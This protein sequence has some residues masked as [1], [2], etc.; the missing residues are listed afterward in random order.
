MPTE[1]LNWNT[2]FYTLISSFNKYLNK[3]WR[4]P[5]SLLC[6][7]SVPG[8]RVSVKSDFVLQYLFI[9][10]Q[11]IQKWVLCLSVQWKESKPLSLRYAEVNDRGLILVLSGSL[12]GRTK[13]NHVTNS[14]T[15]IGVWPYFEP[16]ASRT[17]CYRLSY[18][19][20]LRYTG[21]LQKM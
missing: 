9:Y 3:K 14:I 17:E 7:S 10:S 21:L 20:P 19:V 16:G 15:I 11:F 1:Y 5:W 13:E 18:H 6:Q 2:I 4:V 8:N 12:S